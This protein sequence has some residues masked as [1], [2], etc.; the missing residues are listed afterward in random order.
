MQ[1]AKNWID[2]VKWDAQGLIPVIAQEI[3]S[4]DVLM[5]AWM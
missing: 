3:G 5:F 2:E 4:N 1:E